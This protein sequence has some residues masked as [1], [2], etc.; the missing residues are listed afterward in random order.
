MV[1]AVLRAGQVSHKQV[2]VRV[3]LSQV[4]RFRPFSA[5]K[6]LLMSDGNT[7][8]LFSFGSGK[9]RRTTTGYW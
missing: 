6:Q 8:A 9:I 5:H 4:S 7:V 2:T 3:V 1:A